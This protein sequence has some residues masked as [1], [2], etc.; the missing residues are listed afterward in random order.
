MEIKWTDDDPET[1]DKRYLKADRFGGFWKFHYRVKRRD[2]WKRLQPT[3]AMWEHV[4]D[5][6]ERRYRREEVTDDELR[7]VKQIV[8]DLVARRKLAEEP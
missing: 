7:Q 5:S 4:L 2:I 8:A 6:L 3:I 1:G